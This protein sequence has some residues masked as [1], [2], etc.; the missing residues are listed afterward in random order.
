MCGGVFWGGGQICILGEGGQVQE[1]CFCLG[2][3]S[4]FRGVVCSGGGGG[5]GNKC[6][7][8]YFFSGGRGVTGVCFVCVVVGGG[9]E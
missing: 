8:R 5:G 4:R 2:E 3:G 7:G 9:G 6:V 1:A